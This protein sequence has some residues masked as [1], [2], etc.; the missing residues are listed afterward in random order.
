MVRVPW[1]V[2]QELVREEFKLVYGEDQV[3][4][5]Q[6]VYDQSGLSKLVP[7]YE[8]RKQQ[9]E[10]FLDAVK[11]KTANNKPLEPPK[12]RRMQQAAVHPSLHQVA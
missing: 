8:Q 11:Y 3:D 1:R 4:A 7:E 6:L 5:V 12:V 9:L 2:L 10:D